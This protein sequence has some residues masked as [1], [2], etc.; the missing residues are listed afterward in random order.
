M[1]S[2]SLQPKTE[3]ETIQGTVPSLSE[4]PS[5]CRF[6]TRCKYKQ[7]KC[8]FDVPAMSE[9]GLLHQVSCHFSNAL[10]INN[11]VIK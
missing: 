1:P 6:S 5:G 2:L 4:M 9:V 10:V 7:D 8:E 3:L 11:E